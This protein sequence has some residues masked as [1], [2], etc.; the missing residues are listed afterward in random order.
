MELKERL[1]TCF[2]LLE[3]GK[4]FKKELGAM[5]PLEQGWV[6]ILEGHWDSAGE[7]G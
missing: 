6:W 7:G 4:P 5:F 2:Q 1:T 3:Q